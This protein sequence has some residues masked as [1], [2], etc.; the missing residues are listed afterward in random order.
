MDERY[1]FGP[2]RLD[3][4]TRELRRGDQ[5]VPLPPKAFDLLRAL[6]M[7]GGRAIAKEALLKL[8]WP[9]SFVGEDSLA[10][11]I[12]TLRKALGDTA[13]RQQYIITVP[14]HGYR[15][16]VLVHIASPPHGDV[17]DVSERSIDRPAPTVPFS[18]GIL[19]TVIAGR[20]TGARDSGP[21]D[22]LFLFPRDAGQVTCG[23]IRARP[24]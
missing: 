1:D 11:T 6:V 24:S 8:V 14:R 10:Q 23:S 22:F 16:A 3:C 21:C 17:A 2:F 18:R 20:H 4:G 19:G 7:S 9:D 12:A 13:E 15:F 5:L